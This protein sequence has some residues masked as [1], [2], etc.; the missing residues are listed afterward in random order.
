ME[1]QDNSLLY[2]IAAIVLLHVLGGVAILIYRIN[3]R[4]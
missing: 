1:M 3:K 4:D 2:I